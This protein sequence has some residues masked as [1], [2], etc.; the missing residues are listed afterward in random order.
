MA[1]KL[2]STIHVFR[3]N[4]EPICE[5]IFAQGGGFHFNCKDDPHYLAMVLSASANNFG[6]VEGIGTS[7]ALTELTVVVQ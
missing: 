6:V 2:I 3:S 1:A 5:V 4:G 7:G